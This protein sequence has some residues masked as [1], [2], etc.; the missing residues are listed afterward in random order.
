MARSCRPRRSPR[1]C[2]LRARRSRTYVMA[3]P[4]QA[5]PPTT[6][7]TISPLALGWERTG[8]ACRKLRTPPFARA[9]V[10]GPGAPAVSPS[11]RSLRP[12]NPP[13]RDSPAAATYLC[14]ACLSSGT[15]PS[16][17]TPHPRDQHP[18][19]VRRRARPPA[20]RPAAPTRS[21]RRAEPNR[22]GQSRASSASRARPAYLR[23]SCI[24]L[25]P[26]SSSN[27]RARAP[28]RS[29]VRVPA[30]EASA[31]SPFVLLCPPE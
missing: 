20:L 6:Q 1:T 5:I 8:R 7:E 17:P 27:A 11:H 24:T 14:S 16:L 29:A 15:R 3:P 19:P 30:S 2:H 12:Q 13:S 4:V 25:G 21:P 28:I 10:T 22:R 18:R 9:F 23:P 26:R 31:F